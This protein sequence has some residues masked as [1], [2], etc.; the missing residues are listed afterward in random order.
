MTFDPTYNLTN[1]I[2]NTTRNTSTTDNNSNNEL[3][4][5]TGD[6]IHFIS[7]LTYSKDN[8][9]GMI[10][11]S[12][13]YKAAGVGL[14]NPTFAY[15]SKC[16]YVDTVNQ[17]AISTGENSSNTTTIAEGNILAPNSTCNFDQEIDMSKGNNYYEFTPTLSYTGSS[18][19]INNGEAYYLGGHDAS[20][21][22]EAPK[23][24]GVFNK[25][26]QTEVTYLNAQKYSYPVAYVP[27]V[28]YQL[29][30][31]DQKGA[32]NPLDVSAVANKNYPQAMG[33]VHYCKTT[34]GN[35]Q[36]AEAET[37]ADQGTD[38]LSS[39]V[40]SDS[41]GR[42]DV[43][44]LPQGNYRF[45]QFSAPKHFKQTGVN[46]NFTIT[47]PTKEKPN[48]GINDQGIKVIPPEIYVE[49]G[50]Q[51]TGIGA[52]LQKV[53]DGEEKVRT[54]FKPDTVGHINFTGKYIDYK[55]APEDQAELAFD[56]NYPKCVNDNDDNCNKGDAGRPI[57]DA[58]NVDEDAET[59]S[60]Q[61]PIFG[62]E[63]CVPLPNEVSETGEQIQ[64]S[65]SV[66]CQ[67]QEIVAGM[68][69]VY[70][71]MLQAGDKYNWSR[72]I[73]E[74]LEKNQTY[75][76]DATIKSDDGG[77][78]K[79]K[80]D[81]VRFNR[82][83]GALYV[84]EINSTPNQLTAEGM[85]SGIGI[86]KVNVT[87]YK[88]DG[89]KVDSYVTSA[90]S[91]APLNWDKNF[92]KTSNYKFSD[93]MID[94]K[95]VARVEH[96][97]EGDY[98]FKV[99]S[100]PSP[101]YHMSNSDEEYKFT[102]KYER[103]END[104][105]RGVYSVDKDS[106]D[107]AGSFT[108][109][110]YLTNSTMADYSP[111]IKITTNLENLTRGEGL[112]GNSEDV[113]VKAGDQ[114]KYLAK[115]EYRQDMNQGLLY[116]PHIHLDLPDNFDISNSKG[117]LF[118]EDLDYPVISANDKV[119]S[120]IAVGSKDEI[121]FGKDRLAVTP[122]TVMTY[123]FT[124][125]AKDNNLISVK[126]DVG[127]DYD[128]LTGGKFAGTTVNS[129]TNLNRP[130]PGHIQLKTA[131]RWSKDRLIPNVPFELQ[132]ANGD[133]ISVTNSLPNSSLPYS[134][135]ADNDGIVWTDQNAELMIDYLPAGD[136]QLIPVEN[137]LPANYILGCSTDNNNNCYDNDNSQ[138][139]NSYEENNHKKITFTIS[140]YQKDTSK[141]NL[142][143]GVFEL[144][145]QP[146]V[147]TQVSIQ[148]ITRKSPVSEV[149]TD[150]RTIVKPTDVVQY[151]Y[152]AVYSDTKNSG[153]LHSPKI[154]LKDNTNSNYE[155]IY[156]SFVIKINGKIDSQAEYLSESETIALPQSLEPGTV[157]NIQYQANVQQ[158][159]STIEHQIFEFDHKYYQQNYPNIRSSAYRN[160]L[161]TTVTE[162]HSAGTKF[163]DDAYLE[164]HDS[165][166]QNQHGVENQP[167]PT[168]LWSD[169]AN[170]NNQVVSKSQKVEN[171]DTS[172]MSEADVK[173]LELANIV[174]ANGL[175][176]EYLNPNQNYY[177]SQAQAPF[178][179]DLQSDKKFTFQTLAYNPD[180]Y[181]TDNVLQTVSDN[182]SLNRIYQVQDQYKTV[183]FDYTPQ[184]QIDTKV[185]NITRQ[186]ND[187][188]R[189]TIAKPGDKFNIQVTVTYPAD[190]NRGIIYGATVDD[191][192]QHLQM[193]IPGTPNTADNDSERLYPGQ[194]VVFNYNEE[195]P[196]NQIITRIP[197]LSFMYDKTPD[198]EIRENAVTIYYGQVNLSTFEEAF[199]GGVENLGDVSF[200][201]VKQ[202][203]TDTDP[204]TLPADNQSEV[205]VAWTPNPIDNKGFA[206]TSSD[207]DSEGK[208]SFYYL[209]EG[210]YTL[211]IKSTPAG[212]L[213]PQDKV[214]HFTVPKMM[215]G[216]RDITGLEHTI[217][218]IQVGVRKLQFTLRDQANGTLLSDADAELV[219]DVDGKERTVVG[220]RSH[221]LLGN[222]LGINGEKGANN[223]IY[224]TDDN[225]QITFWKIPDGEYRVKEI[226][227][228][229][230][231]N[232]AKDP[233]TNVIKVNNIV[234]Q[235]DSDTIQAV[236]QNPTAPNPTF[237]L[238][239]QS[240]GANN[241]DYTSD[242]IKVSQNDLIT[243][244][245]DTRLSEDVS[246]GTYRTLTLNV[247]ED[248]ANSISKNYEYVDLYINNSIVD[249]NRY[250][251]S[252]SGKK[253]SLTFN[254]ELVKSLK[255]KDLVE[256]RFQT[257]VDQSIERKQQINYS[258]NANGNV[259][260]GGSLSFAKSDNPSIADNPA[261]SGESGDYQAQVQ[262]K[263]ALAKSN[264]ASIASFEFT[265]TNIGIISL[266]LF[267]IILSFVILFVIKRRKRDKERQDKK[268]KK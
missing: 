112:D 47:T 173:N 74:T 40:W 25:A 268:G 266:V 133:K 162:L 140:D 24:Q 20:K 218:P 178:G 191:N 95:G 1:K 154:Q 202:G 57:M 244:K 122:G 236:K 232:F 170:S 42:I 76:I 88:A 3:I 224:R 181:D 135:R 103:L 164:V 167:E 55:G 160:S 100:T 79:G 264:S 189:T 16:D 37:G 35:D 201:L 10:E 240:K 249:P 139:N 246:V 215:V 54:D 107:K 52:D 137:K 166:T 28:V 38:L 131:E 226:Q 58:E 93:V 231:Y 41:S 49:I 229:K 225:G 234:N 238:E 210:N 126:T 105:A 71:K 27:N 26:Y 151:N 116:N 22:K 209:G 7:Q 80:L 179:Y 200:S 195:Y 259:L 150:V 213:L 87:L 114:V 228:P 23:M 223:G 39:C 142:D 77:P 157:I 171:F 13:D 66:E 30:Q 175:Y 62:E 11:P 158:V 251:I 255:S 233:Q 90:T 207:T 97:D 15:D 67:S 51:A 219:T 220:A 72:N 169:H 144:Y 211:Q 44:Y 263:N 102:V 185:R 216:Q 5:K 221:Q 143:L 254:D 48:A 267:L 123:E 31:Q 61:N 118:V 120:D 34:E 174:Q 18:S 149:G 110:W 96:L 78:S 109:D 227:A 168:T 101:Y 256:L 245:M 190:V 81:S 242:L 260:S 163:L 146:Q 94:N 9:S 257:R 258:I 214:W 128:E 177:L 187:Y 265:P 180:D 193:G 156:N 148:D 106:S 155:I 46:V 99:D 91:P 239:Q 250:S 119:T 56:L 19:E 60:E 261:D 73:V 198:L 134:S 6:Q 53:G 262:N 70:Q 2:T 241:V 115:I 152:Q 230:G 161:E 17:T 188:A 85:S 182:P 12:I 184:V 89:T 130:Y 147:D 136:Y 132:T 208:L 196:S 104:F 199:N 21:Y 64:H 192:E 243:Y 63:K 203:I 197:K 186:G 92:T 125:V 145:Y 204:K 43:Y 172:G 29:Q 165:S 206:V 68:Y 84:K 4:Y 248:Q 32:W 8:I 86:D 124:G 108:N 205:G 183:E 247:D 36:D 159:D 121:N 127:Y 69:W 253:F 75:Q 14:V 212:N 83:M 45:V 141:I 129:Q 176:I 113:M 252:E 33:Q 59:T 117:N 237:S 138:N 50:R 235:S 217:Q 222:S 98:Y 111:S 65:S 153:L 82:G 194:S